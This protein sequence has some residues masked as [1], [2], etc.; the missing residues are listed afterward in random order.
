MQDQSQGEIGTQ[1]ESPATHPVGD[2]GES[3]GNATASDAGAGEN[4]LG[5]HRERAVGKT[6]GAR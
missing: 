3:T 6:A 5:A 1:Q 4:I 2:C